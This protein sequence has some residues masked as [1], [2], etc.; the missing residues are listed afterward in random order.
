MRSVA[1]WFKII[2]KIKDATPFLALFE[3]IDILGDNGILQALKASQ[4]DF[5]SGRIC[6]HDEAWKEQ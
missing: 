4:D 5:K 3:T 1:S 2:F 6:T